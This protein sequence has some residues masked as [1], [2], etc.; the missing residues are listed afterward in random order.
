MTTNA[1][2]FSWNMYGIE[3]IVPV[4][5]YE[6]WDKTQTWRIL[7]G[8]EIQK[9][10][11]GDIL[12]MLQMRARFNSHRAYEIYAIDCDESLTEEYWMEQWENYP[13]ETA[14]LIRKKG[15]HIFGHPN[16]HLERV[17]R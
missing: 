11:M 10:P 6:N 5:Q 14:D 17:I 13:Q 15:V 4:T 9:N 3:S 7:K 12:A 2:I 1:Y 16:K 8:E